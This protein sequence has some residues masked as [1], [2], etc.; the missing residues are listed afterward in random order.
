MLD[1]GSRAAHLWLSPWLEENEVLPRIAIVRD[2]N[3]ETRQFKKFVS[4]PKQP[5]HTR[6]KVGRENI[7]KEFESTLFCVRLWLWRCILGYE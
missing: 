7:Y 5:Y 6:A 3:R 1:K 4:S 2:S